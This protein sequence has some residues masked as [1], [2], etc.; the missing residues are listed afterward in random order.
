MPD[1]VTNIL[2]F[3]TPTGAKGNVF[4]IKSWVSLILGSFMLLVTFAM[5]QSLKNAF[6]KKFTM[7]DTN[8]ES[9]I[10]NPEASTYD[11]IIL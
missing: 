5:G 2:D 1:K 8:I 9:I 3:T 6:A 11:E 4:S 7:V 10:K